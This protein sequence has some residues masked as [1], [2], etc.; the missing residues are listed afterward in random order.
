MSRRYPFL[1]KRTIVV[2]FFKLMKRLTDSSTFIRI[3]IVKFLSNR[4]KSNMKFAA[5]AILALG[6]CA[7]DAEYRSYGHHPSSYR[8]SH[9]HRSYSPA[10]STTSSYSELFGRLHDLEERVED[11]ESRQVI[12]DFYETNTSD[13]SLGASGAGRLTDSFCC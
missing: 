5:A 11:L 12:L 6:A 10:H 4:K 3:E 1:R 8:S 9:H 13:L 7:A 2:R